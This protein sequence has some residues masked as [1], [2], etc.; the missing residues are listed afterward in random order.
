MFTEKTIKQAWELTQ[1]RLKH[2]DIHKDLEKAKE[3]FNEFE[4]QLYIKP[5]ETEVMEE[6]T[7]LVVS[8]FG[9][10]MQKLKPKSVDE[11]SCIN[12]YLSEV[13]E[14]KSNRT[15]KRFEEG[16]YK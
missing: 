7:D 16:F 12:Q 10:M 8:A 11:I 5:E 1:A 14:D 15:V 3:E 4:Q 13:F 9:V 2:S 6:F